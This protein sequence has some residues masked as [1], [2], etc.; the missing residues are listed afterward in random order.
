MDLVGHD[1]N[2]RDLF[3]GM[4]SQRTQGYRSAVAR[5]RRGRSKL[6]LKRKERNSGE[7]RGEAPRALKPAAGDV[8]GDNSARSWFCR[9]LDLW[10]PI[11]SPRTPMLPCWFPF[12]PAHFVAS[13]QTSSPAPVLRQIP[14]KTPA[15]VT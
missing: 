8:V 7:R 12:S 15:L 1:R 3:G 6:A 4:G 2:F 14:P 10:Q 9:A 5:R 11:A 13:R